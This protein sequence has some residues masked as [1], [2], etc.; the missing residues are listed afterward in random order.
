MAATNINNLDGLDAVTNIAAAG[1]VLLKAAVKRAIQVLANGEPRVAE[2]FV[3]QMAAEGWDVPV[4]IVHEVHS[5]TFKVEML[6]QAAGRYLVR[7]Y[8]GAAA[9]DWVLVG[10]FPYAA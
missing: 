6:K 2:L 7:A 10:Q 4:G 3:G 5:P 1:E 8:T 9:T